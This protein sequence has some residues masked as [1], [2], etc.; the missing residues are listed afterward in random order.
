MAFHRLR[1]SQ[2]TCA[3]AAGAALLFGAWHPTPVRAAEDT[4]VFNSFLG[5]FGM[6][7]D[8]EKESIDYRARAPLVVPPK[9]DLP[10]PQASAAH[11]TPDWPIDPDVEARRKAQADSHR[12][13]P[14][15]TPNTRVEM[16]KTELLEGRS[17]QPP[18]EDPKGNGCGAFGGASGCGGSAWQY[19][20]EKL[21]IAKET[22]DDK[23]VYTGK[24]PDR[25][26]LTEPPPGYRAPTATTKLVADRPKPEDDAGDAQ[27]YQRKEQTH[28]HSVD[29]Q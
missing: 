1:L 27:A 23:V 9:T 11:R 19:V 5:F 26:Y 15:I 4:N 14:Q 20:T 22:A 16:S 12:P 24:E 2:K 18:A 8:K 29:D 3:A 28:K 10:P 13:A 21:G 25:K 6:Q 7:A 17:D